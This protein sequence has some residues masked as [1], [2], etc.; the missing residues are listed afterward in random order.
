MTQVPVEIPATVSGSGGSRRFG[1]LRGV[2][3]RVDLGILPSSPSSSIDDLRRVTADSRRRYAALRRQ[4][5]VDPHV[6]KDGS[7]S[8]DLVMDN[9][10]SQDPD[11]MWGRFFRNAELER[12]VDQDLARL[13]PERGS[14]FQT[15]ECQ[16]ML[17]RMLLLWCLRHPKY[18]YR[19]GMHELLAPL[20]Y[21]LHVDVERLSEVRKAHA[22]H[23][24]DK[25]GAFSFHEDDLTYKFDFKRF[26]ESS[27]N[28]N[29]FENNS[30]KFGSPIELDPEI[31]SIVLLT[32]AYGAEG[33]LGVVI[34]EKF[35]EHDA[36]SMFDAL[37][38]G[39]GGAVAMAEFFS[40]LPFNSSN[41]GIPPV[42]EASGAVYHLLSIVDSSL[43][44][45]LVELGVEP[46]YFSLR[47]LRVLFGREF[48]LEDLLEIWD[49]IFSHENTKFNKE[50]DVNVDSYSGV[51]CSFRGGFIS[52]FAVSVIL[53]LRSSLLATENA[54]ACL[55]RLLNFSET[56]NL[57][58]LIGKAKSL[59][60]LAVDASKSNSLITHSGLYDL[61][62]STHRGHSL[63]LDLAAS[64]LTPL[65]MVRESYWE[66]RW[67][68]LH[69]EV[70]KKDDSEVKQ[71]PT[72][73][74]GWSEKVRVRLSRTESDPSPTKKNERTI[75]KPAVRRSLLEDLER[76]L[77]LDED[78]ETEAC[79][80][81][82][83]H[84]DPVEVDGLDDSNEK[85]IS[86]D[87]SDRSEETS[88]NISSA[89]SPTHANSVQEIESGSSVES[90]SSINTVQCND[91]ESFENDQ[92]S[93]P[94][95]VSDPL[96]GLPPKGTQNQ[97]SV[98]KLATNMERKPIS[99][100]FQWLW[101]FGRTAGEGTSEKKSAP[102][103]AKTSSGGT[104]EYDVAG[105]S[106][107]DA[108]D[109]SSR[110][111]KAE[112]VDQNLMVSLRN[113]GQSM[114]ENIQ[115]IESILPQDHR[116][117]MGSLDNISKNGL[118]GKGQVTAMAALKELRKI[119]NLL[120]E[121]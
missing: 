38:N 56:I 117:Q 41:T 68:V 72:R 112:T 93:S 3:W 70:D 39:A 116:G 75:P 2:R 6:P 53:N 76:Q 109:G 59:Q 101:K 80:K 21:V 42:I 111:N 22:D 64:P 85:N 36:Y 79:S 71:V 114:L 50:T 119:S 96:D 44:S 81:N 98:G 40:P 87:L 92:E 48:S 18:G 105:I 17:R 34:S 84:H 58:K 13:Y 32:D 8:P 102:L 63:S 108:C 90:N 57:V 106:T 97:H 1:G 95:P 14:Y 62:K 121:M 15:S 77:G 33:E 74:N 110:L 55:Q 54:T 88:S 11:S 26:S 31:Q 91:S 20:L 45:H 51:L 94:L 7:N 120:S 113:L 37:M 46:Q 30:G 29:G 99:G 78:K 89:P 118:V 9:P 24:A 43:H 4:L 83:I 107:A 65:N 28:W 27:E 35:M 73:K 115:V 86:N 69:K 100:K 49:E 10:L 66:E 52:A 5:L 60:E 103:D 25:F 12:M 82:I 23:F 47:W 19:Q 104:G 16:G 61:R 67:R